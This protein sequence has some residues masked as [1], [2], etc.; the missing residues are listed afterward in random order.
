[1][2]SQHMQYAPA[3]NTWV[4]THTAQIAQG[5]SGGPLLAENG[6][7]VGINTYGMVYEDDSR[8]YAIYTDYAMEGLRELGIPFTEYGNGIFDGLLANLNWTVIAIAVAV[9]M[10]MGGGVVVLLV[11][12]VNKKQ[13]LARQ[14]AEAQ[15]RQQEEAERQRAREEEERRRAKEEERRK[16]Q[17]PVANLRLNGFTTYP[18]C[19]RRHHWPGQKLHHCTACQRPRRQRQTLYA[20]D[21]GWT[22]DSDGYEFQLWN[23][24]PRK[25]HSRRYTRGTENR[26]QL[27][28]GLR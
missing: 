16:A 26:F 20:G 23:H 21:P 13:E 14:Q 7:V 22:A 3:D 27:Q 2:I 9:L 6:A 12:Q 15:R 19:F 5:N 17:A 1:M 4:L 11:I 24:C 10:A 28:P 8:Y 18:T 25:T